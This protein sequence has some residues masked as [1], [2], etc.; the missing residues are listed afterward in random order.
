MVDGM[1]K[2]IPKRK[3]RPSSFPL[4]S[5]S[6]RPQE[7]GHLI[8]AECTRFSRRRIYINFNTCGGSCVYKAI[9]VK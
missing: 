8:I 9:S 5:T 6:I 4:T 2:Y 3:G 1:N 7:N